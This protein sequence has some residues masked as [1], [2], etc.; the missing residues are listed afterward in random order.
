MN[1]S[2]QMKFNGL[3]RLYGKSSLE[4]LQNAHVCL[5]GVGG[6]GSW[7]AEALVRSGIGRITLIDLDEVCISNTNRQIHALEPNIGRPK[8]EVL[9]ERMREIN[10]DCQVHAIVDFFTEST[11]KQLLDAN[12]Y[13]CV[14]D[15]IDSL[16][17]KVRLIYGCW[18]RKIPIITVGG[19]GGRRDPSKVS[20]DDL[21]FSTNDGLLRR[22]RKSLRQRIPEFAQEQPFG[23]SCVYSRERPVY[24]MPD[25][26]V[27]LKPPGSNSFRLDCESGYGTASFVTGAFGFMA[28]SM[29]VTFLCDTAKQ[30]VYRTAKVKA[31]M[32]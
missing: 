10:P 32:T 7:T 6:V 18:Q 8:V 21:A 11:E 13:D 25:G 20:G 5:V 28:A 4:R 12:Y 31:E 15:A 17:N 29:A 26:S 27:C 16:Q 3:E 19:A 9:A 14:I 23:I 30:E 24:P 2:Y 22:V 1:S